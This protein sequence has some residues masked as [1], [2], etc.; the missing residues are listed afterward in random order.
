MKVL[1]VGSGGR[2][3]AIVRAL[4]RTWSGEGEIELLCAPGN[5]GIERDARCYPEVSDTDVE[6]IVALA[7]EQ[8][9]DLVAVGPEAPLVAGLVDSCATA[10]ITAFGPSKAAADLEGSKIF[11]KEVMRAARVPT[12]G[13]AVLRSRDE[14]LAQAAC[15]SYPAVFKSDALAA[16]KGVIICPDERSARAAIDQYFVQRRFG[17]T[18]VILEEFLDG[19]EV[20][21]IALCDGE[22]AYSL[23]PARDY[24][25]IYDGDQGPNTGGMGAFSPVPEIPP[26]DVD[27]I[28][29]EVLQPIV[30]EMKRRGTPF[31]GVL[32][33]GLMLTSR[34]IKVLEY[35]VRF[36][37]PETQA[38]LPRLQS[39]L[40]DLMIRSSVTGGL[41]GVELEC[42][43]DA[44]VTI[45]MASAGYPESSSKGDVIH[46]LDDVPDEIE[47][48]HAGTAR[49][50]AGA[51]VTG[52]GRVLNVTAL[53]ATVADAR[54]AAYAAAERIT[55]PGRQER[56][57]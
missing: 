33:A 36:G 44:A 39:N 51:I 4:R 11:S 38:M 31:H 15:A 56:S 7:R 9:V 26:E 34:G 13:H 8:A 3:H 29:A 52:G 20:S 41:A 1:V 45:T 16:G 42:G 24:K 25:R 48:T 55:F 46:G 23:T 50:D 14:A 37:D 32:Y 49:N 17:E 19:K 21:L 6:A 57:D 40:A 2:E 43:D 47:V 35:N 18:D 28:S 5:P 53:G 10:G 27:A 30:D 22:R 54:V 12:A